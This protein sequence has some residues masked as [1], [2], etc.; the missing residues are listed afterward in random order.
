MKVDI[1]NF[2]V[3]QMRN[4]QTNYEP[5]QQRSD[6]PQIDGVKVY[7]T[8]KITILSKNGNIIGKAQIKRYKSS[9]KDVKI[10]LIEISDMGTFNDEGGQKVLNE[11]LTKL[12]R[13]KGYENIIIEG[14][15]TSI[16]KV[17][18]R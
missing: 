7:S 10:E 14:M 1:M 3:E 13:S 18:P 6:M 4:L 2:S 9:E 12:F 8:P 15:P 5:A 16:G 17:E 11:Q